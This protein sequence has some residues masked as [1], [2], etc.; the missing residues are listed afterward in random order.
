[1]RE[2]PD[3]RF[4]VLVRGCD[5][6]ALIELS[7]LEQVDLERLVMVGVA[8]TAEEAERCGCPRPYPAEVS[9]G[10]KVEAAPGRQ[11]I[12]EV[13]SLADAETHAV[14]ERAVLALHQVLRLPQHLPHVL[15]QGL[16]AGEPPPG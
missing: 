13:E 6:R 16:R 15:L 5:E 11:V 4:A 3:K 8:C 2:Y 12:D 10:D 14:V 1:M 7:K 9:L